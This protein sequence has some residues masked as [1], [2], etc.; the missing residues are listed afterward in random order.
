MKKAN[1]KRYPFSVAKHA[2]S[3][4]YYYNHLYCTLRSME[5]G[6]VPMDEKRYEAIRNMYDSELL[7]SLY[8]EMFNSRDGRIVYLTGEQLGLARKIVAWASERRATHIIEAGKYDYL[9][10][11]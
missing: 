5:C 3:I 2:H 9:Q 10:Y 11:C 7:N 8:D 1:E 6:E 4:E